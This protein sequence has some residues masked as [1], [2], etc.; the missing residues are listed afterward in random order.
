MQ[1]SEAPEPQQIRFVYPWQESYH[2]ALAETDPIE[3]MLKINL[4]ERAI[5]QRL[6]SDEPDFDEHI[7]LDSALYAL[8]F[9]LNEERARQEHGK[10]ETKRNTDV[11]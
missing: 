3:L 6:Q 4:A 11:A 2:A 1:S 9:L 7:Q 5:L 8:R 10:R